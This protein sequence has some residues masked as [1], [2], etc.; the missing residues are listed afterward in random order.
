[1][2]L[3]SSQFHQG[4]RRVLGALANTGFGAAAGLAGVLALLAVAGCGLLPGERRRQSAS[5]GFCTL[6]MGFT[7]IGL[8]ILLLLGFQAAHGYVYAELALLIA[9]FM[10]G[11]AVGSGA[12]LRGAGGSGEGRGA[13][14]DGGSAGVAVLA[15]AAVV[16]LAAGMPA[17][18]RLWFLSMAFVAGSLGGLEFSLAARVFAGGGRGTGTLYALDLAGSC[19]GAALFS[20]YLIPVFGFLR[21]GILMAL[22]TLA[23]GLSAVRLRLSSHR[24]P[25]R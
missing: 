8:E 16:C 3:W 19:L 24:R 1:M 10:A 18:S 9:A 4:Y 15:V 25:A 2:A 22:V 14:R 13:G 20:T 7:A 17:A 12:G 6:A 23:A 11:V 21:T 5:A